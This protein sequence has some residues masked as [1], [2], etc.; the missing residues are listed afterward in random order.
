RARATPPATLSP[1][2]EARLRDL[3]RD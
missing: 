2:E 3:L 1:E